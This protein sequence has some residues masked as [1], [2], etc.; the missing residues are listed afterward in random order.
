MTT[1]EPLMSS[2]AGRC[3]GNADFAP[4]MAEFDRRGS[5]VLLPPVP[6]PARR[7]G[8][9]RTPHADDRVLLRNHPSG[10]TTRYPGIRWIV[11]HAGAALPV[12]A[13]RSSWVTGIWG[14]EG[15]GIDVRGELR[16][17]HYDLAGAPLPALLPALLAMVDTDR[18]LYGSD[19]TFTPLAEVRPLAEALNTTAHLDPAAHR[20]AM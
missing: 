3:V 18:L 11:P 7:R 15:A 5:V 9:L 17:L 2:Y 1:R 12:L 14:T 20:A 4:V 10:Q 13:D 19:A 8:L 16:R 6:P